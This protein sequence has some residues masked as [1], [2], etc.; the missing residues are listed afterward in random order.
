MCDKVILE[1]GRMLMFI[2]DCY[3][4]K[5]LRDNALGSFSECFKTQKLCN[6]ALSTCPYAKQFVPDQFKTHEMSDK[7]AD[8]CPFAFD[9][10]TD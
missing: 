2:S 7:A 3:K 4:D 6:K 1:N 8:N 10:V 5:K 9:S